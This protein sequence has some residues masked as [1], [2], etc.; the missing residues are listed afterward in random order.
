MEDWLEERYPG[1]DTVRFV[2]QLD[3]ATSGVLVAA[4]NKR[5]AGARAAK[6]FRE[7]AAR[8]AYIALVFG[9]PREDEWTCDAKLGRDPSDPK[10]FK[11]RVVVDGEEE[12]RRGESVRDEV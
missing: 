5:A 8:K 12:G 6:L 4:S 3:N 9:H 1:W 7:R 10:G 2:H 11:E